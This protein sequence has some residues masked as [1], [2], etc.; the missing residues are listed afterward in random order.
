MSEE[1]QQHGTESG[2]FDSSKPN[3][4]N[5]PV[6][7]D[8][9]ALAGQANTPELRAKILK[10]VEE[11]VKA[12]S[13]RLVVRKPGGRSREERRG[14]LADLFF[15]QLPA[16]DVRLGAAAVAAYLF[17]P[18]LF[19]LPEDFDPRAHLA[20]VP[21]SVL[22]VLCERFEFGEGFPSNLAWYERMRRRGDLLDWDFTRKSETSADVQVQPSK[23][24]EFIEIRF[25]VSEDETP[26]L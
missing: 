22:D 8:L 3:L 5:L 26:A 17:E 21:D 11:A 6:P 9:S 23:P 4:S 1:F 12:V 10:Q 16:G 7:L 13:S 25:A 18:F 15:Q 20:K 2:R 14:E 24:A 19:G